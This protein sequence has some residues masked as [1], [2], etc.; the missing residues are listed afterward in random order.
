MFV[1]RRDSY[2]RKL[3]LSAFLN[4]IRIVPCIWPGEKRNQII[5][6]IK[7]TVNNS[8]GQSIIEHTFIIFLY[9]MFT[10]MVASTVH[11]C[12]N[13][14]TIILLKDLNA[15]NNRK[16]IFFFFYMNSEPHCF[17]CVYLCLFVSPGTNFQPE[18]FLQSKNNKRDLWWHFCAGLCSENFFVIIDIF[19]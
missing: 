18:I 1:C 11:L 6:R 2:H 14:G 9:Y 12:F 7:D 8:R 4:D 3:R 13:T 15:D 16:L 5:T 10:K 17:T 19:D